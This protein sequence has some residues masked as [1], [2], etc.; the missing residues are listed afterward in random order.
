MKNRLQNNQYDIPSSCP[1][2]GPLGQSSR[3][4]L[5]PMAGHGA[6]GLPQAGDIAP[7]L[8]QQQ[9]DFVTTI[10]D[11]LLHSPFL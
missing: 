3:N 11:G 4:S 9:A 7:L 2:P 10:E 6:H 8:A 1:E 5:D